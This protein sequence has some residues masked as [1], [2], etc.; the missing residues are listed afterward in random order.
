MDLMKFNKATVLLVVDKD[1]KFS[2]VT[3]IKGESSASIWEAFLCSWVVPYIGCP[4]VVTLDEG[5][6]YQFRGISGF[7]TAAGIQKKS[8][9]VESHNALGKVERYHAHLRNVFEMVQLEHTGVTK[10]TLLALAV[11]AYNDTSEP[12]GMVL[13]L[14]AFEV[15]LRM[16]I[17]PKELPK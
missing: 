5:S 16:P 17:H 2:A 6:Q 13:T 3:F 4:D 7:L 10:E 15:V 12:S 9:G 8:A 11:K 14:L 1:T